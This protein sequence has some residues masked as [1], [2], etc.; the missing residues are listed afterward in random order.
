MSFTLWQSVPSYGVYRRSAV[1]PA[2]NPVQMAWVAGLGVADWT[3]AKV[4]RPSAQRLRR[5][6]LAL[7]L[8]V[9]AKFVG[10]IINYPGYL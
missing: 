10:F 4:A 9:P 2:F 5:A 3:R 8:A 7:A 6:R 1:S